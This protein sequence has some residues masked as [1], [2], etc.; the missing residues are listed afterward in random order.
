L[1]HPPDFRAQLEQFG[2]FLSTI[3]A[4][5]QAKMRQ[6]MQAQIQKQR[7]QHQQQHSAA[8]QQMQQDAVTQRAD[9]GWYAFMTIDEYM[10][11]VLPM[12]APDWVRTMWTGFFKS[13]QGPEDHH[14]YDT[15]NF[16]DW[17]ER[18]MLPHNPS[19]I[20]DHGEHWMFE[21]KPYLIIAFSEVNSRVS[22]EAEQRHNL[23]LDRERSIVQAEQTHARLVANV[24]KILMRLSWQPDWMQVMPKAKD[25]HNP[26]P[27]EYE[28][29]SM[30]TDTDQRLGDFRTVATWSGRP[31]NAV[32]TYDFIRSVLS[33]LRHVERPHR[34]GLTE[35]NEVELLLQEPF[36]R[37]MTA[38]HLFCGTLTYD[39]VSLAL[40][41][42]SPTCALPA[43][44]EGQ[45][46]WRHI[47]WISVILACL[48]KQ[49]EDNKHCLARLRNMVAAV[50]WNALTLGPK[51]NRECVNCGW[52]QTDGIMAQ[53]AAEDGEDVTN[54]ESIYCTRCLL[55]ALG[56]WRITI[57]QRDDGTRYTAVHNVP[58]P[59]EVDVVLEGIPPRFGITA[60]A[61]GQRDRLMRN[62]NP[63]EFG[64]LRP[65]LGP[66]PG[67]QQD[68]RTLRQ[69]RSGELGLRGA[70]FFALQD[71]HKEQVRRLMHFIFVGSSPEA[72]SE[73]FNSVLSTP[74]FF[75]AVYDMLRM[76]VYVP[77]AA[78]FELPG[79]DR[80]SNT[81]HDYF[82]QLLPDNSSDDNDSLDDS[83]SSSVRTCIICQGIAV[84]G[85]N[86]VY[87]C[88][89]NHP[90]N[91]FCWSC[92]LL[93]IMNHNY[94]SY[95]NPYPRCPCCNGEPEG[96]PMREP[97][98][99][100]RVFS[101]YVIAPG[102]RPGQPTPNQDDQATAALAAEAANAVARREAE[103]LEAEARA[104]VAGA[105]AAA[106]AYVPG[107]VAA[108]AALQ[109]PAGAV[110]VVIQD[111]SSDDE[112]GD[113]VA[114]VAGAAQP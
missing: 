36:F 90:G 77:R 60:F 46:F 72:S 86:R 32:H 69:R 14:Y 10:Q 15:H 67:M 2:Q 6:Q 33:V 1:G 62:I 82:Q 85:P 42:V 5:K 12:E 96:Q 65:S 52:H 17:A 93:H 101:P 114:G 94:S 59:N 112:G 45:P 22:R 39:Y 50:F 8:N 99:P 108:A 111:D 61:F 16:L 55:I 18:D 84:D 54:V 89:N 104:P 49:W 41:L 56:L 100:A 64:M 79:I 66:A 28:R 13:Y 40:G 4:Q 106:G 58:S 81:L 7:A 34:G 105:D 71:C 25:L 63:R 95:R 23:Q 30:N 68:E 20:S 103:R 31:R 113:D 38:Y 57:E 87:P 48:R 109:M 78:E 21:A 73:H 110:L 92:F 11:S 80:V 98:P 19:I 3:E 26:Y 76:M 107:A 37:S 51:Q 44:I 53:I 35:N 74:L 43:S 24:W 91:G 102:N 75:M 70:H 88:M 29:T 83:G 97:Q 47:V 27:S 9:G